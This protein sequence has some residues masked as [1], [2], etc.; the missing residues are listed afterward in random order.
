MQARLSVSCLLL[1]K[2][3]RN[4]FVEFGGNGSQCA[5][6]LVDVYRNHVRAAQGNHLAEVF[7]LHAL[8]RPDA[9]TGG[10][11]A[12]KRAGRAAA[13]NMAGHGR[14]GFDAGA[15]FD[16]FSD[17]LAHIPVAQNDMAERI[18]FLFVVRHIR[19]FHAFGRDHDAVPLA[20]IRRL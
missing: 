17:V 5:D 13:L 6:G 14:A 12:V 16:L 20:R 9:Q 10:Q 11:D 7:L 15:L 2:E 8:R 3:R 19:Q 18:Q 4:G 1:I